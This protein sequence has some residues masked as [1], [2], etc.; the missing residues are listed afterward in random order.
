MGGDS[1]WVPPPNTDYESELL[2]DDSPN[3]R[4]PSSQQQPPVGMRRPDLFAPAG[5]DKARTRYNNNEEDDVNSVDGQAHEQ[6]IESTFASMDERETSR[7]SSADHR[8]GGIGD[9]SESFEEVER[10]PRLDDTGET[11]QSAMFHSDSVDQAYHS[12]MFQP[13]NENTAH[14]NYSTDWNG[15]RESKEEQNILFT[16]I[17]SRS[18][19]AKWGSED[20]ID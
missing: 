18:S 5:K 8:D 1:P 20:D 19:S 13:G 3:D 7:R 10:D 2:N 6:G 16:N 12:P 9:Q 17:D 4:P 11:L 14:H 15:G